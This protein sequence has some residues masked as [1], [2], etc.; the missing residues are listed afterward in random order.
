[1]KTIPSPGIIFSLILGAFLIACQPSA[2]SKTDHQASEN[3]SPDY[4]HLAKEIMLKAKGTLGSKLVT[5]IKQSGAPYAIDFCATQATHLTD[6]VGEAN[7][8]GIR[9]AAKNFRN[10]SNTANQ[11]DLAYIESIESDLKNGIAPKPSTLIADK[12]VEVRFPILTEELC[13]QCHGI[14]N[15]HISTETYERILA[16][17]PDD[18]ATGFEPNSLRGIWVINL[19]KE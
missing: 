19:E 15:D 4:E 3:E 14:I 7:Q 12:E 1:M 8:A 17:Y 13:M 18:R 11:R 6:S 9:R 10:P 5:A 2:P 16:N